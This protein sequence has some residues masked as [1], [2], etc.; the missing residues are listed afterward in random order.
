MIFNDVK[1]IALDLDGTLLNNEKNISNNNKKSLEEAIDNG[2]LISYASGRSLKSME[3]VL[4]EFTPNGPLITY[5]GVK[6]Y[7]QNRNIIYHQLFSKND[8]I[9]VI[10]YSLNKNLTMII[11]SNDKLYCSKMNDNIVRYASISG[12]IPN[13]LGFDFS[14]YNS[15]IDFGIDK[16]LIYEDHELLVKVKEDLCF[17][18][19]TTVEFSSP[20]YLEFYNK[21]ASKGNGLIIVADYLNVSL[22]NVMAFGDQENDLSMLEIVKYPIIMGNSDDELKSRFKYVTKS[23]VDD[24][25]AFIINKIN[26]I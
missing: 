20:Y 24:G 6:I 12:L 14:N 13:V 18:G 9:N 26:K 21:L 17:L 22:D 5:N 10:K 2:L 8:S 25:V 3:S 15:V 7:D 16:I 11:W 23:N 19:E 4:K 1:L